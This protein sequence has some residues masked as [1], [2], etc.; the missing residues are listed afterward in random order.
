MPIFLPFIPIVLFFSLVVGGI[1]GGLAITGGPDACTAGGSEEIVISQAHAE[2][3]DQKWDDF[4]ATLDAGQ[5]ATVTFSESEVSSRARAEIDDSLDADDPVFEG[6][7]ICLHDG[8]WE[9]S[10]TLDFPSFLD[11][12]MMVRGTAEI[13]DELRIDIDHVDIGNIPSFAGDRID[14]GDWNDDVTD[15]DLEHTYV[16]TLT[17]GVATVEGTP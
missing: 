12:K 16:L 17:E 10:A 5:P 4:E 9:M 14:A 3:F 7:R 2:S 8:Y 6:P 13:T 11:V 1:V 15:E